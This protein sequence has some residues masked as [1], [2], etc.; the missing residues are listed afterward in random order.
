MDEAL[1]LCCLNLANKW[2]DYS[3]F[4]PMGKKIPPE[5]GVVWVMWLFLLVDR[6][7]FLVFMILLVRYLL[8]PT[9]IF[10]TGIEEWLNFYRNKF[11]LD[12]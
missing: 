3:K 11:N 1:K 7:E 12:L 9:V 5:R 4:H 2:I 10:E 6:L 8:T